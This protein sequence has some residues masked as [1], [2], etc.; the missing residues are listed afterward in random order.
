MTPTSKQT[1]YLTASLGLMARVEWH[2]QL[3]FRNVN[4]LTFAVGLLPLPAVEFP[5]LTTCTRE[6][7]Y[8]D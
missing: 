2:G 7:N 3:D 8:Q 6:A 5:N 1:L 4:Y